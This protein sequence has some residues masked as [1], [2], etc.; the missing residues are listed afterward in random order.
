MKYLVTW[1]VVGATSIRYLGVLVVY[2]IKNNARNNEGIDDTGPD[3]CLSSDLDGLTSK[4]GDNVRREA[5]HHQ[6]EADSKRE[7]RRR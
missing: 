1:I 4:R 5:Y 3:K 2:D 6:N 7:N